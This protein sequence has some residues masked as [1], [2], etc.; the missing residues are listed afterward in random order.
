MLGEENNNSDVSGNRAFSEKLYE[1]LVVDNQGESKG[2]MELLAATITSLELA[3]S[4]SKWAYGSNDCSRSGAHSGV[5][6][7]HKDSLS[8]E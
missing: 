2:S 7:L 1:T 8:E 6:K 4:L 5:M 3:F